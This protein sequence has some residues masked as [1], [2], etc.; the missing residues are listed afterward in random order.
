MLVAK[1]LYVHY[2]LGERFPPSERPEPDHLKYED[3]MEE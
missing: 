2:Y 3:E 1:W